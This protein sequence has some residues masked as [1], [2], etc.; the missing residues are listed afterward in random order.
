MDLGTQNVMR[1]NT[2]E[3]K[4]KGG[5]LDRVIHIRKPT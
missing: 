3:K 4:S 2:C 5:G 1:S